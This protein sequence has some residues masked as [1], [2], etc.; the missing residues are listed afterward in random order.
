M[1]ARKQIDFGIQ[2]TDL[3]DASA[4][5]ALAVVKKPAA[6]DELLEFVQAVVDLFRLFGELLVKFFMHSVVNGLQALVAD[7]LIVGVERGA[8]ILDREILDRFVKLGRG[9]V[10]RELHL[11][12]ADFFADALDELDNL[13][14]C[15]MAE[16]DA[17]KH[18]VVGHFVRARFD[19]G[20]ERIGRSDGD[21]HL[22][23]LTLLGGGVE[24]VF[25]VHIT[26]QYCGNGAFPGNV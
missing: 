25:P 6:H 2:G 19:H 10:R 11:G 8:H 5:H 17:V 16:H 26:Q 7:T 13:L 9:V 3:V 24:H 12:L 15:L 21:R 23:F 22:R 1:H 20:D 4:V 18:D 14:V